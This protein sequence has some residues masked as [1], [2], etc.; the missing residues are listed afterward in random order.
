MAQRIKGGLLMKKRIV[1]LCLAFAWILMC[2]AG[3]SSNSVK[4]DGAASDMGVDDM[5]YNSSNQFSESIEYGDNVKFTGADTDAPVENVSDSALSAIGDTSPD[6]KII[7]NADISLETK[8]FDVSI[9]KLQSLV[10]ELGGY[11]SQ[12]NVSVYNSYYQLHSA[13]YTI[14]IPADKF[15]QFLAY[16]EDVGSI[17]STNVWTDD[18]TDSYY[19]ME[20][21]LESLETKR[22]RLLELLEKAETMENIIALESELSNT[23][24]EIE[25][26]T[27]SLNRLDD[28]IAFSTINVYIDEVRETTEPV[29]L[30]KTLGERI[31]QQFQ[32]TIN[33]LTDF[34]ENFIVWIVGASPVLLILAVAAVLVVVIVKHGA[35]KR[36]ARREEKALKNAE[37]IAR[38]R[39]TH[40]DSP[41]ITQTV[42]K[43]ERKTD[44]K[45]DE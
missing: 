16:R 23:I 1:A 8:E 14:R 41:A 15:D 37:A 36:A 18:V 12:A 11:I 42:E 44:S 19:D 3:C 38:W 2:L 9:E 6:R 13:N 30:P 34:G 28:R 4:M 35:G 24:Y 10:T 39:E 29:A 7:R 27:G 43:Q 31:S 20:A 32:N 25:S 26:I 5:Y 40:T 17:L 22:T 45:Q 21:R 33:G